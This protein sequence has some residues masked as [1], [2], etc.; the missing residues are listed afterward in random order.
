MNIIQYNRDIVQ[1]NISTSMDFF[2]RGLVL[3]ALMK[4]GFQAIVDA[5]SSGKFS[6]MGGEIERYE[7]LAHSFSPPWFFLWSSVCNNLCY[8]QKNGERWSNMY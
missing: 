2:F 7:I 4:V 5:S 8:L 6:V 1:Q 3:R